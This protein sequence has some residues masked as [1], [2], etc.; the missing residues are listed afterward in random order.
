M[1]EAVPRGTPRRWLWL[2]LY[3]FLLAASQIR[4]AL[5]AEP[6]LPLPAGSE[7]ISLG[8]G[9]RALSALRWKPSVPASGALPILLL[10]GS[11]GDASNF[12]A[13][14]AR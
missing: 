3:L 7:R 12:G 8:V 1:S 14:G 9:E 5:Q 10:H 6:A 13:L 11:P 4:T 2:G